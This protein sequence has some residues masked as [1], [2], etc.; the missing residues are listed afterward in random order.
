[1]FSFGRF[2]FTA[3]F[4]KAPAG[5][6]LSNE[7]LDDADVADIFIN[8]HDDLRA[9]SAD[10]HMPIAQPNAQDLDVGGPAWG[11]ESDEGQW[12]AGQQHYGQGQFVDGRFVL[13]LPPPSPVHQGPPQIQPPP[14]F[15]TPP[16]LCAPPPAPRP[17]HAIPVP[18]SRLMPLL[19]MAE[20]PALP[21]PPVPR[22]LPVLPQHVPKEVEARRLLDSQSNAVEKYFGRHGRYF[23]FIS[24]IGNGATNIACRV[25]YRNRWWNPYA[26]E[27]FII[28]RAYLPGQETSLKRERRTMRRLRGSMH[29][30]QEYTPRRPIEL[31]NAIFMEDLP[32]G[33]LFHMTHRLYMTQFGELPNRL[34]YRIFLC[35]V[36]F[37]IALA[38]PQNAPRGS[39]LRLEEVP[40]TAAER[41]NTVQL[42]HNDMHQNNIIF[43]NLS[44]SIMEHDFIPPL[45][46]IDLE[47]TAFGLH[48]IINNMGIK[49]NI[50]DI[51]R[52][53]HLLITSGR[54]EAVG[55]GSIPYVANV[56]IEGV[57]RN[58]DTWANLRTNSYQ[59]LDPHLEY[60]I[61]RCLALNPGWRPT[62]EELER[63]LTEWIQTKGPDYF[64]GPRY[65][66]RFN[67]T[68]ERIKDIINDYIFNALDVPPPPQPT[69]RLPQ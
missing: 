37:A 58:I 36:R 15:G 33:P 63:L 26:S 51:G 57:H 28:K 50:L 45:K 64:A 29:I 32:N 42:V 17:H 22:F 61:A 52:V 59:N 19:R 62:L 69:P 53:M 34:L 68:D 43:G 35:H 18:A 65:Y 16:G 46:L 2:R 14:G 54:G 47:R 38:Y 12:G 66:R 44:P 13:G 39:P 27:T 20:P 1:M 31:E 5:R 30:V 9:E 55:F 7:S 48:P 24:F 4:I 67:E 6:R 56:N 8:L 10:D 11:Y 23:K 49:K 40:K 60:L 41:N 21:A 25:K 3:P